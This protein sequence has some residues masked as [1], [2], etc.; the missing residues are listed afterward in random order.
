MEY[1]DGNP[2]ARTDT[3]KYDGRDPVILSD[4]EYERL[5]RA[6]SRPGVGLPIY[7]QGIP[8]R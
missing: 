7:G 8:L 3:P 1:R 6:L 5:L 4:D 2:V